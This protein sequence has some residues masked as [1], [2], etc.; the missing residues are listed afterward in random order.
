MIV[1]EKRLYVYV[2]KIKNTGG[3]KKWIKYL[4]IFKKY[5]MKTFF[6]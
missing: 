2:I 3:L 1:L 4:P 5:I 6:R